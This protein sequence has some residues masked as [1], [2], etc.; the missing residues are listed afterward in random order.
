MS[1]PQDVG[2]VSGETA[3]GPV[4]APLT[5][6]AVAA[7]EDT[8]V[9]TAEAIARHKGIAIVTLEDGTLVECCNAK[10]GQ[11]GLVLRF[12]KEVIK[13]LNIISTKEDFLAARFQALRD[14]PVG[15]IEL[16]EASDQYIW[17]VISSLTSLDSEEDV[18]DLDIDDAMKISKVLWEL[19]KDFFLKKVLPIALGTIRA[20]KHG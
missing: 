6:E 12:L 10:V 20:K 2:L 7:A 14:D 3:N 5:P 17:K 16:F 15:I 11:I 13:K 1:N 9:D 8:A 18:K 19:N 4:H